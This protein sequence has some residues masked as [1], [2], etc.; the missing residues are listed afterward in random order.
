MLSPR[1][2]SILLA[3]VIAG[4]ATAFISFLPHS[5]SATLFVAFISVLIFGSILIFFALDNLVFKEVNELYDQIKQI[6]KKNFP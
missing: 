2:L 6:K 1:Y 3:F 5:D 4:V